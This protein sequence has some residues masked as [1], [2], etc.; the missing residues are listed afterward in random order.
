MAEAFRLGSGGRPERGGALCD[1]PLAGVEVLLRRDHLVVRLAECAHGAQDVELRLGLRLAH[2]EVLH[3][4]VAERHLLGGRVRRGRAGVRCAHLRRRIDLGNLERQIAETGRDPVHLLDGEQ[5]ASLES[6]A[7]HLRRESEDLAPPPPDLRVEDVLLVLQD[8]ARRALTTGV[9]FLGDPLVRLHHAG[10]RRNRRT[11]VRILERDRDVLGPRR[12]LDREVVDE[13]GDRVVGEAASKC[14]PLGA[15]HG[16]VDHPPALHQSRLRFN[17]RVEHGQQPVL[18]GL[19]ED[20]REFRGD[21]DD[22]NALIR[23]RYQEVCRR[24]ARGR[25]ECRHDR[26]DAHVTAKRAAQHGERGGP[27]APVARRLQGRVI[28]NAGQEVRTDHRG[29]PLQRARSVGTNAPTRSRNASSRT[30]SGTERVVTTWTWL[31][32]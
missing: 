7:P 4:L 5:V 27:G 17:E 30:C 22:P 23:G 21:V 14:L 19:V 28:R 2:E 6:L 11:W 16:A 15:R 24:A 31:A 29:A 1:P 9:G 26:G 25:A 8:L 20:L 3:D 32:P 12:V 10:D 13:R 18:L